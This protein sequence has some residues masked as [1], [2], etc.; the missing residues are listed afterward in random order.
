MALIHE[1][2]A[3]LIGQ[4]LETWRNRSLEGLSARRREVLRRLLEGQSEKEIASAMDRSQPAVHEQVEYIYRHFSVNSRALLSAYFV[5]RRPVPD[6]TRRPP[7][8]S[9]AEW[10]ARTAAE[11]SL[12][13]G[14]KSSFQ[15]AGF[16]EKDHF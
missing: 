14:P 9:P 12:N 3:R 11:A 5:R 15:G 10:L 2:I 6:I 16:F 8:A 4:E 13:A 1:E 7:P